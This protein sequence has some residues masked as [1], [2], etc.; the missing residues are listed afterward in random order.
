MIKR[1]LFLTISLSILVI[2]AMAHRSS[3]TSGIQT[4]PQNLLQNRQVTVTLNDGSVLDGLLL[5]INGGSYD[6]QVKRG[7][8]N[9][10]LSDT[11]VFAFKHG[12]PTDVLVNLPA[13]N[14]SVSMLLRTNVSAAQVGQTVIAALVVSGGL[15][16]SEAKATLK[17]DPAVLALRQ[18]RD[19]GLF[20]AG[21]VMPNLNV[22]DTIDASETATLS[23]GN[24][25]DV[26]ANGQLLIYIF[27]ALSPGDASLTIDP[28]QTSLASEGG[29]AAPLTVF[30]AK[31][32]VVQ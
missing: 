31:V 2:P 1:L 12:L 6:L 32:S 24:A 21:G 10:N 3:T 15:P 29:S 19:G 26:A 20:R 5:N 11:S 22:G 23:R 14:S 13:N 17:F 30:Y 28:Q 16:V 25:G 27:E 7:D 8:L 9:L 4:T 18:V